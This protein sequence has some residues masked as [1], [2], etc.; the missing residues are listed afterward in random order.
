MK[1]RLSIAFFILGLVG[2]AACKRYLDLPP[3]NQ[4]TVTTVG[5]VKSLL[6]SYL[7]GVGELRVKPLYGSVMPMAPA[8]TQ[9]FFEAYSD[10]IDFEAA[11]T[12]TY[13]KP[14][15]NHLKQ[16]AGYADLL[17]WNKF[18]T[19]EFIW[20][21]HYEVIG[22]L[23][24]LIDQMEEIKEATPQERDQLLGEMYVHRAYY[25]FKLLE[26]F[27]PY[28]KANLGIPVYLHTGQGVVGIDMA[29]KSHAE[30]YQVILEDLNNALQMIGKTAPLAGYNVFYSKRY[31][32]HLLAQ[33][34]WFKAES[35]AK[36]TSDYEK[37]KTHAL[38]AVEAVEAFIPTTAT[39]LINAYAAKDPNYP[40]LCMENNSQGAI[41]PI[42][43]SC[44]QYLSPGQFGPEN[45][46]LSAEFASLFTANDIRI[47]AYFNM[48]PARAGGKV[49]TAGKTLGWQWPTDGSV[50]GN[51]KRGNA[52]LFK[53]EE[54]FLMLAEAQY[55]L[56]AIGDCITTLNKFK[57]FR[58]AG[59]ANGLSGTALLNEITNERRK[60]FFGDSDKRWLD[61]KRF[62][63]KTITR[64]LTF[65]Q[66]N[67]TLTVSPNDYR[68]ALPIP[69]SE[70]Q[71]N[72]N[73]VPNEGWVPIEY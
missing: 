1:I 55:R 47:A 15:N 51:F 59:T 4:R 66:K 65:F 26:Y 40:A 19:P 22:F 24:S 73:I 70:I 23:N 3:K 14:N 72:R 48:D 17:L 61:L 63:N 42:Y 45:I 28:N 18:T 56:N 58:N 57:S 9:V 50:T 37:V 60:E 5:D 34:Y 10:N 30:V 11:V 41:S 71:E 68:Y 52:C 69:L 6:A 8:E 20:K 46:P 62:A 54:A 12:Q 21:N 13:L 7:K 25:F 64:N 35:P 27:A 39:A 31:I 16:E 2:L 36:E 53:P 49:G 67:Y 29:R 32:N 44:F 33:V 38:G 43:G